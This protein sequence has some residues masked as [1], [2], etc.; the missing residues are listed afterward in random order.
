MV[1]VDDETKKEGGGC[2]GR[3]HRR[4]GRLLTSPGLTFQRCFACVP[5]RWSCRGRCCTAAGLTALPLTCVDWG[6][7]EPGVIHD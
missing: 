4:E 6:S 2:V 3:F 7:S 1:M 5:A